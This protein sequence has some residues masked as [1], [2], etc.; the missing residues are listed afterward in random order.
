MEKEI[1]IETADGQ[2]RT[3]IAHPDTEGPF[4]VALIY[5]DGVGYRDELKNIARRY[6][7]SG[8]YTVLADLYH[9]LGENV[10]FDMA[11]MVEEGFDGPEG[12]RMMAAY[13]QMTPERSETYTQPLLGHVGADAAASSGP[14][15]C[16]GFCMGARLVLRTLSAFPEEFSAGS[17]IHPGPLVINQPDS[18]HHELRTVRGELYFGFAEHDEAAAAELLSAMEE[19]ALRDGVT[20]RIE[21]YPGTYH[22]FAVSDTPVFDRDASERHFERTLELWERNA[23]GEPAGVR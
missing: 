13:G 21:V 18:P 17:G 8:Y 15:V 10:V 12:G 5:M 6:A 4:P 3:F 2:M 14:K 1:R 16:L 23:A 11:K 19:E 22:G 9:N 20:M 7:S